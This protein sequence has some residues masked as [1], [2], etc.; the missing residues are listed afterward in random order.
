MPKS[1]QI[2]ILIKGSRDSGKEDILLKLIAYLQ[3]F[4]FHAGLVLGDE[5]VVYF[6]QYAIER[7]RKAR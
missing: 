2:T 4:D 7:L 6:D 5:A 1:R 3:F